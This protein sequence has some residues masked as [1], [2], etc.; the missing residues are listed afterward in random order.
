MAH[1]TVSSERVQ[2]DASS[3][4]FKFADD[5]FMFEQVEILEALIKLRYFVTL[6][7]QIPSYKS[8]TCFEIQVNW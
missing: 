7:H 5:W 4:C 6:V 2:R 3:R 1:S 8:K